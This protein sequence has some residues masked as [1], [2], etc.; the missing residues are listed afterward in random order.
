M[1]SHPGKEFALWLDH[2]GNMMRFMEDTQ[3]VF[4]NGISELNS[5]ALDA[6]LRKEKTPEEKKDSKCHSCGFIHTQK[7]CPACGA[8]RPV[9]RS[10]VEERAGQLSEL[11]MKMKAKNNWQKD[12]K[13]VW[14]EICHIATDIKGGDRF[15]A[16]KFALAQYRNLYGTWPKAAYHIDLNVVPREVVR[17][18]VRRMLIAYR[19]RIAKKSFTKLADG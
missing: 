6:K 17:N 3:E 7:I 13:L 10:T 1:R 12:K 14:K 9:R 2:A 15:G 16:E 11:D 18:N 19:H 4:E 5:G 8:E